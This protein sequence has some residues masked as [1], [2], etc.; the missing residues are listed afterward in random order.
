MQRLRSEIHQYLARHDPHVSRQ[1]CLEQGIDR[2][3]MDGGE[4]QRAGGTV[5][6][7]LIEKE[8][9][10]RVGMAAIRKGCLGRKDVPFEPFE[11]LPAI[12]SDPVGLRIMDMRVDKAG[13]HQPRETLDRH[14]GETRGQLGMVAERDDHT[15]LDHHQPVGMVADRAA[16]CRVLGDAQQF[17]AEGVRAHAAAHHAA[18]WPSLRGSVAPSSTPSAWRTIAPAWPMVAVKAGISST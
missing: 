17:G 7:Q 9:R 16:L 8:T 13:D 14:A 6:Q 11:Q 12:S 5:P 2:L 1:R 4:D 15:L 3:G 18:T 10:H